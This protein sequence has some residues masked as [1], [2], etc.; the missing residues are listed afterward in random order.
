MENRLK[1]LIHEQDR[2]E[3]QIA[4]AN[5]T[6]NFAEIVSGLWVEMGHQVIC[7]NPHD[8]GFRQKFLSGVEIRSIYCPES[9]LGSAAHFLCGSVMQSMTMPH[10]H[11]PERQW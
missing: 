9:I 10:H 4:I 8:H 2:L 3:K 1:E 11:P 6:S 5:K 7:Y